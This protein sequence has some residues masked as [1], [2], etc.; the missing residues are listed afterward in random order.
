MCVCVCVHVCVGQLCSLF[1]ADS[2]NISHFHRSEN[3]AG[4]KKKK[5]K[6]FTMQTNKS[7]E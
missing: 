2:Q 4:K 5:F 7:N 3:F 1:H 6:H